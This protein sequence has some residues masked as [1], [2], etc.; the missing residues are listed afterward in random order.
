MHLA[1]AFSLMQKPANNFVED[2]TPFMKKELRYGLAL[3]PLVGPP[4]P[5]PLALF[6]PFPMAIAARDVP[7]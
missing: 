2:L 6:A 7:S 5:F 4:V 3:H 1:T